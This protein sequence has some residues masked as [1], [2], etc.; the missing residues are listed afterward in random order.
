M[1]IVN[2]KIFGVGGSSGFGF[3]WEAAR[4]RILPSGPHRALALQFRF[5]RPVM[6]LQL[7]RGDGDPIS[8]RKSAKFSGQSAADVAS[9][10]GVA[11]AVDIP[12]IEESV[13]YQ[14]AS[15]SQPNLI[16]N[17]SY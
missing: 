5:K 7:G 8:D 14:S 13:E 2:G 17:L 11:S 12:L 4:T 6:E 10:S 15:I 16:R 1:F 9:W 3:V